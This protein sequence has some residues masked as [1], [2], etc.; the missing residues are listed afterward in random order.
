MIFINDSNSKIDGSGFNFVSAQQ[1]MNKH[2][3]YSLLALVEYFMK[4][5][6]HHTVMLNNDIF[7]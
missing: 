7:Q 1:E 5:T 3:A 4:H 2:V 6:Q